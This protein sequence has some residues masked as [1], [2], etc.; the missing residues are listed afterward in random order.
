MHSYHQTKRSWIS[1]KKM[2]FFKIIVPLLSL[3]LFVSCQ[4][5]ALIVDTTS[6]Q[7]PEKLFDSK[8]LP[9]NHVVFEFR[10]DT[11]QRDFTFPLNVVVDKDFYK[12]NPVQRGD[13]VLIE[14]PEN[15]AKQDKNVPEESLHIERKQLLRV[16]GLPG[17]T[18]DIRKGQVFIN[19]RKLDTFYGRE[20]TGGIQVVGNEAF[21]MPNSVVVPT[22]QYFLLADQW[23][24]SAYSSIRTSTYDGSV[25]QGKIVGYI[26]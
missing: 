13:I 11:M 4:E 3:L 5:K 15:I 8:S 22:K 20:Y 24:R 9:A 7:K 23:S 6:T 26:K 16:V 17:E 12:S 2:I 19:D 1:L 25:I 14:L 21:S 10:N 18:I